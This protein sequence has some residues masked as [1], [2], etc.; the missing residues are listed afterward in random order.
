MTDDNFSYWHLIDQFY[1]RMRCMSIEK[2]YTH[3]SPI[4]VTFDI[5][6]SERF[7][8]NHFNDPERDGDKHS[9]ILEIV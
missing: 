7:C 8:F 1:D 2:Q 9:S 3:P 5:L 4:K 6:Q